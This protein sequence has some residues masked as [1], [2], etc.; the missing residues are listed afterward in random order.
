VL[1]GGVQAPGE[2]VGVEHAAGY[3][4]RGGGYGLVAGLHLVQKRTCRNAL[5]QTI[6]IV[7][8]GHLTCPPSACP[9]AYISPAPRRRD[10]PGRSRPSVCRARRRSAGRVSCSPACGRT[11]RAGTCR[12]TSPARS[13]RR[14]LGACR[15]IWPR[16]P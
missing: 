1:H 7:V 13:R 14:R 6:V 8:L 11:V 3:G 4:V 2:H 15:G 16:S 10:T 12:P 9:A 5:E